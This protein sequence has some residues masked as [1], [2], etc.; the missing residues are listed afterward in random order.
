MAWYYPSLGREG[1]IDDLE[2]AFESR[3]VPAGAGL[4][5]LRPWDS[6][7]PAPPGGA[8]FEFREEEVHYSGHPAD[9]AY[10]RTWRGPDTNPPTGTSGTWYVADPAQAKPAYTFRVAAGL[11]AA[12]KAGDEALVNTILEQQALGRNVLLNAYSHA[13]VNGRRA[14]AEVLRQKAG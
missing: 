12:V 14:L 5:E 10:E 7:D 11:M 8:W 6:S 4:I 1:L 2:Q 13:L 9:W 3:R